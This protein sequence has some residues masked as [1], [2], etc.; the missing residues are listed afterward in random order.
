VTGV[1]RGGRSDRLVIDADAHVAEDI[2]ALGR[3]FPEA[4]RDRAPKREG[5]PG[6]ER[7]LSLNGAML[8]S[9][10]A[11][12]ARPLPAGA[13]DPKARVDEL[14]REGIDATVVFPTIGLLAPVY[15]EPDAGAAFCRVVN[16]WVAS[17]CDCAP[18]RLA[19]TALLPQHDVERAVGELERMAGLGA[20]AAVVRPNPVGDRTVADPAFDDLWRAAADRDMAVILHEGTF[21]VGIATLAEGR[22]A[23]YGELHA[24]A[25]PFELMAVLTQL[26]LRG[27]FERHPRLRLGCFEAGFGWAPYWEHRLAGHAEVYGPGSISPLRDSVWLTAE[28]DEPLLPLAGEV[29]WGK[30]VCFATDYPHAD[31]LAPGSVA[32][33]RASGVPDASSYLAGNALEL[34]GDRLL[35]RVGR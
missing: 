8:Q 10:F 35:R 4:F 17:F 27:V 25:H 21:D 16:D 30:R 24:M 34:F 20:V 32:R 28:P 6:I 22:A 12:P 5:L 26:S 7:F 19:P 23:S 31:A 15:D 29:G 14:D 18:T 1:G 9:R 2:D 13:S 3:A 33:V 11:P